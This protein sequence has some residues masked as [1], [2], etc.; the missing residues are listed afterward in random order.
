MSY[1]TL[2][3]WCQAKKAGKLKAI[4]VRVV[5]PEQME[6]SRLKAELVLVEMERDFLEKATTYFAKA[7]S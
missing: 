2:F 3:N 7:K 4:D 5:S 6:I 1:H